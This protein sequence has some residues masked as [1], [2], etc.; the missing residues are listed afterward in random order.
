M[1]LITRNVGKDERRTGGKQDRRDACKK[2]MLE[3][4]DAGQERCRTG[5]CR[6]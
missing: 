3:I 1:L 2:R 4:R 5:G 6:R